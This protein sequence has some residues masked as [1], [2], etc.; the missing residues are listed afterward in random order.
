LLEILDACGKNIGASHRISNINV[1]SSIESNMD[2]GLWTRF[3]YGHTLS[4]MD[5]N[6]DVFSNTDSDV[7][8]NTDASLSRIYDNTIEPHLL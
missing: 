2:V 3:D 8:L 1:T 6:S 4:N 5:A 7:L